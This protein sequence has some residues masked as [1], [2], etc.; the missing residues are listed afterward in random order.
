M[1]KTEN[2]NRNT[3]PIV[4]TFQQLCLS[5]VKN[6][7]MNTSTNKTIY[8][9]QQPL[10]ILLVKSVLQNGNNYR[11]DKYLLVSLSNFN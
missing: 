3:N 6:R 9:F 10:T 7:K 11:S 4:K 8:I 2:T 5:S 1:I